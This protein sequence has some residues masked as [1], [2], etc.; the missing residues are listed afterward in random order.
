MLDELACI[1]DLG[2]E[3]VAILQPRGGR[4]FDFAKSTLRARSLPFCDLTR[5]SVWPSGDEQIG[6]CTINS[7]KGLEF[8]HVLLPGLNQQVT[9]HGDGEGDASLERLR[10]LLA[11]GVGRARRSVMVGYKPGEASSLIGLLDPATYDLVT[12]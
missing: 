2:K 4:W 3:S 9:P 5:R 8:D 11:M 10:R 1:A 7:A 6:L 12:V